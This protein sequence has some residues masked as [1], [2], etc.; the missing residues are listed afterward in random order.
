MYV[1][2]QDQ[3]AGSG[4]DIYAQRF[5]ADGSASFQVDGVPLTTAQGDQSA[6]AIV[7]GGSTAQAAVVAWEDRRGSSTDI[8]MNSVSYY[9]AVTED[10][11][12]SP[13]CVAPGEQ[14]SIAVARD[15]LWG[16]YV[17][18]TDGRMGGDDIYVQCMGVG[19]DPKWQADGVRIC[20]APGS[21][22]NPRIVSWVPPGFGSAPVIEIVEIVWTDERRGPEVYDL[23]AQRVDQEGGTAPVLRWT[24]DGVPVAE[25]VSVGESPPVQ[26]IDTDQAGGVMVAWSDFR[27]A[28]DMDIRAQRLDADGQRRWAPDDVAV[29]LAT[30]HQWPA[31]LTSD[32]MGGAII[33]W[34]ERRSGTDDDVYARRVDAGG[35]LH[36]G[37]NG[38]VVAA[39]PGDQIQTV[40]AGNGSGSAIVAWQDGRNASPDVYAL[41]T[42]PEGNGLPDLAQSY[43]VPQA[44]PPQGGLAEGTAATKFFRACPN[45]DGGSSLPSNARIKIVLRDTNG[46]PVVGLPAASIAILFNGGTP[47]QGGTCQRL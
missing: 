42:S 25:G 8:Y 9:G 34:S 3:R 35:S 38:T 6:P 5:T 21:Q 16:A 31:G 32:G 47:A 12:G 11:N 30:G 22:R 46:A 10:P 4:W 1:A 24:T 39:M 29:C 40:I 20:G 37:V 33:T 7:W 43:F 27:S 23:Y 19:G 14:Y 17:A 45:N 41:A 36:G 13:V 28:T 44:D 18:W 15:T 2:W 26:F